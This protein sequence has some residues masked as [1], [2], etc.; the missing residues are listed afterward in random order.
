MPRQHIQPEELFESKRFGYTQVVKS[1]G[2]ELVFIAG[3]TG[4]NKAFELVGGDDL[5]AQAA[6][7]LRNL[8][9]ALKAA[10]GGPG[11]VT[12][13]RLYIVDYGPESM[14]A[15][16]APLESFFEGA[17]LPA[18]TLIGVQALAMPGLRIEIEAM[19]V[20]GD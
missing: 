2:G 15:I 12:Q 16:S 9:H 1:R 8:G 14:G 18:Q 11:D 17:P 4:L 5:Q 20:V 10:G 19:A 3:Q 13:L 7:A 6:E